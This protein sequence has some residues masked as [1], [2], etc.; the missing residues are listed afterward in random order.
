MNGG[1]FIVK[2]TAWGVGAN[3]GIWG[4]GRSGTMWRVECDGVV[5]R[6]AGREAAVGV[7]KSVGY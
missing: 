2:R 5:W 4:G 6:G 1:F 3:M 7:R